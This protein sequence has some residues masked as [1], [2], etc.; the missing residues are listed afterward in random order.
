MGAQ[1]VQRLFSEPNY[2]VTPRNVICLLSA[3]PKYVFDSTQTT[4]IDIGTKLKNMSGMHSSFL[5]SL[6]ISKR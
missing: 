6:K 2:F 3:A 5:Y 4:T 1:N